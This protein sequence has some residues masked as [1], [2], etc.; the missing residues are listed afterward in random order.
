MAHQL[1]DA[2]DCLK[3]VCPGYDFVSLFNH[4]HGH[5]QK[6]DGAL[7]APSMS[8]SFGGEQPKIRS[9]EI[10]EGCHGPFN[11]TLKIGDQSMVFKEL[12]DGP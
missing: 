7:D 9:S 2:V 3:L 11:C 12:H 1:E 6:K 8:R 5:A 10:V 4:S